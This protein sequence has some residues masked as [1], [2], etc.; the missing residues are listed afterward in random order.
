MGHIAWQDVVISIGQWLFFLALLPSVFSND[1]PA[2]ST[3][4][5]TGGTLMVFA[6]TYVTLDLWVSTFSTLLVASTW[7]FLSWQK[8]Q[9]KRLLSK[10]S[11]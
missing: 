6:V 4:I 9:Q 5:M 2:L 7:F 11:S 10:P 8:Y 1:K 3:S